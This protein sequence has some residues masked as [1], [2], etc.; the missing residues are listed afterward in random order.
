M[1]INKL[2]E[3]FPSIPWIEDPEG[4]GDYGADIENEIGTLLIRIDKSR[5]YGTNEKY[6]DE[7]PW[8][9]LIHGLLNTRPFVGSS[10][11]ESG[12]GMTITESVQKAFLKVNKKIQKEKELMEQM[13]EEYNR[14]ISSLGEISQQFR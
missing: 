1:T 8:K 7:F 3:F 6:A 2:R 4:C 12:R 10:I 9:T 11:L 13:V 5:S 14:R